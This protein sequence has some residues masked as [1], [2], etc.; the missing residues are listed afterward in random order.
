MRNKNCHHYNKFLRGGNDAGFT[1]VEM[2][3]VLFILG[4]VTTLFIANYNA[5]RGPRSLKIAQNQLVTNIRKIQSY[6]LSAR[7]SPNGNPA[8]MY[9]IKLNGAIGNSTSYVLQVIDNQSTPVVTDIETVTFPGGISVDT[10]TPITLVSAEGGASQNPNCLQIGFSLP[11]GKI[12]ADATCTIETKIGSPAYLDTIDNYVVTLRI[13]DAAS[14][15]TKSV[16]INGVTGSIS[17]E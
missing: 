5:L 16:I 13:I 9:V 12:Y 8:R 11:F 15:M 10:T 3:V 1:L 7:N 6:T 14:G 4:M 17:G 2:L